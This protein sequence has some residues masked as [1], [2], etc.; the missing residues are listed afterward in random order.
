[1]TAEEVNAKKTR[2]PRGDKKPRAK[3]TRPPTAYQRYMKTNLPIFA[4]EMGYHK[5]GKILYKD[6]F[7]KCAKAWKKK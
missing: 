7:R 1:M 4:K 3:S 2:R 5:G 6:V